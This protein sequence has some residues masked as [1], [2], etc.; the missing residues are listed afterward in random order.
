MY[1]M[2]G[3]GLLVFLESSDYSGA[4]VDGEECCFVREIVDHPVRYN[5]NDYGD[6]TLEDED[7]SLVEKC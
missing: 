7:P 3:T 5:T 1:L 4:V 2:F 6:Q